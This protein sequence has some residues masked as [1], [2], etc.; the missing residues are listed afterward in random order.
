[1]LEHRRQHQT[2]LPD[3][4]FKVVTPDVP[5]Q[6]N[7]CDCGVHVCANA[8]TACTGFPMDEKIPIRDQVESIVEF[9]KHMALSIADVEIKELF[10]YSA[11]TISLA[12]DM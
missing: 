8:Y 6:N 9:R 3:T 11:D 7:T 1:M 10:K 5:Q 12:S 2:W 4:C